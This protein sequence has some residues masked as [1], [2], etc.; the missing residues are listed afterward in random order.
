MQAFE[1]S[2]AAQ[3]T[4]RE[5]GL[6]TPGLAHRLSMVGFN[7]EDLV[8][9]QALRPVVE[10]NIGSLV[11]NFFEFLAPLT[12]GHGLLSNAELLNQAFLRKEEHLRAMVGGVYGEDYA[13]QRLSLALIYAKAGLDPCVFLGAFHSLLK[14]LGFMT[15]GKYEDRPLEGFE[16]FMALKKIAFFDIGIIIDTLILERERSLKAQKLELEETQEQF[17][18]A[19]KME[20]RLRAVIEK[21]GD[22]I[23]LRDAKQKI[24]YASPGLERIS[25]YSVEEIKNSSFMEFFHQDDRPSYL[26][27]YSS[28]KPGD[29]FNGLRLRVR[30]KAGNSR[31]IEG[32][33]SN[34][35]DDDK[36]GAIVSN[37]RDITERVKLE[38]NLNHAIKMESFGKLAAGVAHDFNNLITVIFG[39][40]EMVMQNLAGD[41]KN[42][43]MMAT[44]L[45]AATRAGSL[46]RQLLAFSRKQVMQP[47]V[48]D[49][50]DILKSTGMMLERVL[51]EDIEIKIHPG[52]GLDQVFMDPDQLEQIIMNLAVNARDAMPSGGKLTLETSNVF[53]DEEYI[54]GHGEGHAGPHVLLAISDNG[55]G[56]TAAIRNKI[57]EPFFTTKEVGKGTG[58]GLSTVYGI[59][60]QSGGN[61]WV[62]SEVGVGTTFKVYFP[63]NESS[64]TLP[65]NAAVQAV[66]RG[67]ETILLVEDEREIRA[68]FKM[69]LSNN[70]Y[71]V[72]EA[73]DPEHALAICRKPENKIDLL[74]TDMIM[75]KMGGRELAEN[76]T[77]LRPE[78]KVVYMSGYTDDAIERQGML[79]PGSAFIE[80]PIGGDELLRRIRKFLA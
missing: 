56:M 57:F 42:R 10:E 49:L 78:I 25:G 64:K 41:E 47:H 38:E 12:A 3:E 22:L 15:M 77:A 65:T 44:I 74:L 19:Q 66:E 32:N 48:L 72:L 26:A 54:Q 53:L 46:T 4:A 59:V 20:S 63:K 62:Y 39:Y 71:R 27:A 5:M 51:G 37:F 23:T 13:L 11:S 45:Q 79:S 1:P 61:I 55:T 69:V 67:H 58:L 17:R 7:S 30:T 35:L 28:L 33:L 16:N 70:G 50:N 9:V 31:W 76:V 68:L 24:L 40:G 2:I 52:P 14:S 60:K 73:E 36:V 6:D 80:K 34:F 18:G 8:R 29:S 75:P 43:E 21:S